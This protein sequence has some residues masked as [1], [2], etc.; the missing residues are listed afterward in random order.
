MT[1]GDVGWGEAQAWFSGHIAD[2][3]LVRRAWEVMC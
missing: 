3:L 2:L 1:P